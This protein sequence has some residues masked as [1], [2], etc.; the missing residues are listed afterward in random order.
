MDKLLYIDDR[1]DL[2]TEALRIGIDSIKFE[3]VDKLKEA[4]H[5]RG[6]L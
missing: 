1:E 4:M 5:K 6:V 3:D 2:V